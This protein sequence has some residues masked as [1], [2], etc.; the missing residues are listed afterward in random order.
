MNEGS[1]FGRIEL[2]SFAGSRS[3]VTE[4]ILRILPK[5]G[6]RELAYAF[7]S[8]TVGQW[9]LKSTAYGTSI[10]SMRID[11]LEQLPFPDPSIVPIEEVRRHVLRA[12]AAR[13]SAEQAESE[14]IRIVEQEVL[15]QWLA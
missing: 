4:H 5:D 8:T 11:L 15:P 1:L 12:E 9:L 7:L 13:I 3:G 2:G 14:A 10:P 6:F